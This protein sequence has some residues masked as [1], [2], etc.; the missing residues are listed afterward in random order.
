MGSDPRIS[1]IC[2]LQSHGVRPYSFFKLCLTRHTF[3]PYVHFMAR[4]KR[5]DLAHCLYHVF[6]RTN[7]GDVCFP[8]HSDHRK[9]LFYLAKYID[10]FSFRVHAWCLMPTHFHLLMESTNRPALSELMR[11]LLTA[12]TIYFN[13]RHQRHGHLFQGRFKSFVVDKSDYLLA[14]SRYIHNNP[15]DPETF[16]GSSLPYYLKGGEPP[17][18]YTRE[19]LSWFDEDRTKYARFVREGLDEKNKPQIL[20][21]RYIA[22][23]A[24]IRRI[25]QRLKMRDKKGSRAHKA[26]IKYQLQRAESDQRKLDRIVEIVSEHFKTPP[27][28]I[29]ERS[30]SKGNIGIARSVLTTLIWEYMPWNYQDICDFLNFKGESSVSYH[31]RRTQGNAHLA[32]LVMDLREKIEEER[33]KKL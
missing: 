17:F 6:S 25:S 9:F 7:S 5:I 30:G 28:L 29:K 15:P 22:G 14:L 8:D 10:I 32:N 1:S 26:T 24:F 11:R 20:R 19:I 33:L 3:F 2:R 27:K 16:A 21:Q 13:R 31:L 18:L 12:Y 23:K 4:P